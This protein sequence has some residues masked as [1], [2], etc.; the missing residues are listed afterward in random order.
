MLKAG[1]HCG[2]NPS[3]TGT[4]ANCAQC[5]KCEGTTCVPDNGASC[6]DGK[7]CTSG[8]GKQAGSDTCDGGACQGKK[9]EPDIVFKA[10][11]EA[12]KI[13]KIKE[14]FN[15]VADIAT[16]ASKWMP[17]WLGHLEPQLSLSEEKGKFCCE[18]DKKISD[19]NRLSGGGGASISASCFV[20]LSSLAPELPPSIIE[21][22][23]IKGTA[24][25][26][27]N[28]TVSDVLDACTGPQWEEKGDVS[29]SLG[30]SVVIV[31]AGDI[32]GGKIDLP[33]GEAK[34]GFKG[35][36][37]FSN[38]EWTG[39]ACIDGEVKMEVEF[40]GLKFEV[41]LFTLFDKVCFGG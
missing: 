23:G 5:Q 36:N 37:L 9:I 29:F 31:K 24:K 11:V 7:F 25:L 26:G 19:G 34:L 17:C 10:E 4:A 27:V 22:L 6:D 2:G 40:I 20:G 30:A 18:E 35:E 21:A 32:V 1:W 13:A 28:V 41:K 33:K 15:K 16:T 14:V 12:D 39:S 38:F 3:P 8:D